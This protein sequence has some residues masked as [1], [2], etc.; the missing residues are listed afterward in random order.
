MRSWIALS[1]IVGLT[2][3]FEGMPLSRAEARVA[4]EEAVRTARGEALT[5]GVIEVNTDFTLG[6]V[7]EDAAETLRAWWASQA[8]CAEVSRDGAT[9]VVDFGDLGDLCT[10]DG[11]TYGGVMFFTL[12]RV[13]EGEALVTHE[14]LGF[15]DGVSTVDGLAE[16]TWTGGEDPTRRVAHEASWTSGAYAWVGTGDRIQ[17]LLDPQAGLAGGIGIDGERSWD[18]D[19]GTWSLDI[20][21]VEAHPEDPLPDAG[22]YSLV[23]P[24]GKVLVLSFD[25]TDDGAIAVTLTGVRGGVVVWV[26]TEAGALEE[27]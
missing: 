24:A 12:D 4:V 17:T 1:G 18:A 25:R 16:V 14:W 27:A 26:V 8:P 9:V 10:W 2:G 23:T 13:A 6:E 19:S 7:A 22:A 11:H 15:T 3:C 21:G 5:L 20:E